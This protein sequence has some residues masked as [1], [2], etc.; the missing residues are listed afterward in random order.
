MYPSNPNRESRPLN[1]LGRVLMTALLLG[2]MQAAQAAE[3]VPTGRNN[4]FTQAFERNAAPSDHS[5]YAGEIAGEDAVPPKNDVSS[6]NRQIHWVC[7]SASDPSRGAC[8]TSTAGRF[9][10]TSIRVTFTEQRSKLTV[11]LTATGYSQRIYGGT[12]GCSTSRSI[13]MSATITPICEGPSRDGYAMGTQ[14]TLRISRAELNKIPTGGIWVANLDLRLK[15]FASQNPPLPNLEWKTKLIYTV[16]DTKSIEVYLPQFGKADAQIDLNLRPQPR[17]AAGAMQMAGTYNLDVCLY[18]GFNS[19]SKRF[20]LRIFDSKPVEGRPNNLFSVFHTQAGGA[21]DTGN[22]IDYTVTMP[23]KDGSPLENGTTFTLGNIDQS[24]IRAVRIP[25]VETPVVC[26]PTP[27]TLT[28][29]AFNIAD[30]RAGRYQG[31]LSIVF[32]PSVLAP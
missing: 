18:D 26:T 4:T 12:P 23:F 9:G 5:I 21:T 25:N 15:M 14:L 3:V 16:T 10:T 11:T 17:G 28:T 19:N 2:A 6:K 30:K 32:T 27:L 31:K 1:W 24:R 7:W 8:T 13:E 20:D 22:R 29:P